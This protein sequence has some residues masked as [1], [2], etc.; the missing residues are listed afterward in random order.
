MISGNAVTDFFFADVGITQFEFNV[1]NQLMYLGVTIFEVPMNNLSAVTV[2]GVWLTQ[3][4]G[5]SQAI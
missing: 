3:N 2:A 4:P 5:R 1:G